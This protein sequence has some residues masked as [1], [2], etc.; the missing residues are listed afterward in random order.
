MDAD[1]HTLYT[2]VKQ[3]VATFQQKLTLV[4]QELDSTAPVIYVTTKDMKQYWFM[5]VESSM[6]LS[7][8]AGPHT[9]SV[10]GRG[11]RIYLT[12][13][14]DPSILLSDS[15]LIG[16]NRPLNFSAVQSSCLNSINRYEVFGNCAVGIT[17]SK[18]SIS[19]IFRNV[20]SAAIDDYLLGV[21][22]YSHFVGN[23]AACC[24]KIV[25][26]DNSNGMAPNN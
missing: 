10:T 21:M 1:I 23:L 12:Q 8:G 24:A 19:D 13:A 7:D 26:Y 6:L 17:Q 9:I 14:V 20:T 3:D 15:N 5:K 11:I 25:D 2:Y 4:K 18:I 16:N 22:P